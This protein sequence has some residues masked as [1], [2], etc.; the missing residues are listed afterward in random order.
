MIFLGIDPGITGALAAA[1]PSGKLEWVMDMPVRDAGKKGR[2][3]QEIDGAELARLLRPHLPDIAE[4]WIEEVHAM[5]HFSRLPSSKAKGHGV[6]TAFGLGDSRGVIR[7]VCEALGIP[8]Q[9]IYPVTWKKRY[10][11]TGE[12]KD[13]S[14]AAAI[15]LYPG[16]EVLS[17]RK[18]HGRAEAILIARYGAEQARHAASF[19]EQAPKVLELV[20]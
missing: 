12:A 3:A 6:Q 7:G 16:C 5:P 19:L 18:D 11:L 8:V 10:G 14:R 17:R 2:K 15:R 9:R 20:G 13:A 1:T 4:A